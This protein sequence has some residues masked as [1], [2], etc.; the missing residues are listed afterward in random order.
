MKNEALYNTFLEEIARKVPH[1]TRLVSILSNMLSI[2]KEAV[3][4][5]LRGEMPFTFNEVMSISRELHIS[6]DTLNMNVSTSS[7]P[8][9]LNLIEYI[10]PA[11]SDFALMEEMTAI[12]KSFKDAP[13]EVGEIANIIPQPLYVNYD[14]IFKFYLFKWKY[15]SQSFKKVVPYKDIVVSDKLKKTQQEYVKW[16]KRLNTEYV[17]DNFLFHH[18]VSNIKYFYYVGLILKKE[19]QQIRMDLLKILDDMDMLSR[20]G[21]LKESGK[22][23]DMYIS[24]INIDTNYIYVATPNYKL[25]II[26]AFLLNGIASTDRATFEEVKSW[27]QSMKQ[28][29]I[30]ITKSS[31]KERIEFFKAQYDLVESLSQI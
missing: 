17:F 18:L 30:L 9:K 7:K 21:I 28:Q 15:Q 20:T 16:A 14:S 1:R 10:N 2:S 24:H 22:K 5:R 27:I 6:L 26:K 8:F 25:T 13:A 11:E 23:I 19:V 29:S 31:E 4:R 3:Y 12:M